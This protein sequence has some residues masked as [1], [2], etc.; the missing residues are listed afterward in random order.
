M[1]R[2]GV[3]RFVGVGINR[4]ENFDDLTQAV[5]E[6]TDV[7]NLLKVQFG[8]DTKVMRNLTDRE[9]G[10]RV[11]KSLPPRGLEGRALIVLWAGHGEVSTTGRLRL[12]TR[13]AVQCG[14]PSWTAA[15]LAEQAVR[16]GADQVLLVFDTCFSGQARAEAAAVI[17]VLDQL[18]QPKPAWVGVLT[19]AQSCET[20][21]D[22]VFTE[23]FSRVLRE[24]PRDPVLRGRFN[25]FNRGVRGDDVMDAVVQEW[26]PTEQRPR[27]HCDGVANVILPNPLYDGRASERVA[28][29]MLLAARGCE[30]DEKGSYFTGRRTQLRE[31][32]RWIGGTE[33][34]ILVVTGPAG[35]GKSGLVGRIVSLSNPLERRELLLCESAVDDPGEESVHAHVDARRLD[36]TRVALLI[37]RQLR[38]R[39]LV[40]DE[41]EPRNH[42]YLVAALKSLTAPVTIVIDGVDQADREAWTICAELIKPMGE[43]ARVVVAT[44]DVTHHGRS[45]VASLQG[46][47]S[48]EIIDLGAPELASEAKEDVRQYVLRRLES[49][50]SMPERRMDPVLVANQVA[51]LAPPSDEGLFL[52]ARMV[53]AQ[54]RA[55]P[56]DTGQLNWGATLATSVETV[57]DGDLR[58]LSGKAPNG[59]GAGTAIR[60]LLTA[61]AWGYG[62]G[63]TD[64]VWATIASAMP[65]PKAKRKY[66]TADTYWALFTASRY[67]V[68]ADGG[69]RAV[70]RLSHQR[71]ATH[72]GPRTSTRQRFDRNEKAVRVAMAM[73]QLL[74]QL[75]ASREDPSFHPYRPHFWR[76]FGAGRRGIA[77]LRAVAAAHPEFRPDLVTALRSLA[78]RYRDEGRFR[79][80]ADA[81]RE[82]DEWETR[83]DGL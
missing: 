57:F 68:A 5:A 54:L 70:Y 67:V 2:L 59:V 42:H 33:A 50:S 45:L 29:H 77:E 17:G 41:A 80:E 65:G 75:Y 43:L 12:I 36:A 8:F 32:A 81:A 10:E 31:I 55:N 13:D 51:E 15:W 1:G 20:A 25:C 23:V 26:E 79:D 30:P 40:P 63:V 3:P 7:A 4:Y 21:R 47:A 76:H 27:S 34:G 52:L 28:E 61:L 56:L 60:E 78:E 83:G 69:G 64:D 18:P 62:E 44:R 16:T 19:S 14:T 22:G 71:F 53:T 73:R 58:A 24:G 72:L 38:N 49:V 82:A 11:P 74:E 48:L 39:A 6:V 35:S 46:R 66:S 37:H 9:A